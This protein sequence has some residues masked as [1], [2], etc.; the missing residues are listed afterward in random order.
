MITAQDKRY[1]VICACSEQVFASVQRLLPKSL[2]EIFR[3]SSGIELLRTLKSRDFDIVFINAPLSEG[4]AVKI[5]REI[6]ES[7]QCAVGIL[8]GADIFAEVH[9]SLRDSGVF[10]VKKPVDADALRNLFDSLCVCR[11]R[12]RKQEKQSLSVSEKMAE[13][14]LV[15]QAKLI[16]MAGGMSESEAHGFILKRSMDECRSKS[17]IATEIIENDG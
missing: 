10:S 14:K 4:N 7:T 2:Y 15:S 17:E 5:A 16:L 6:A 1:R 3:V 9:S 12:L 13:I 8:L 11:E